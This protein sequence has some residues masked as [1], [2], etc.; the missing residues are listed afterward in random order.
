M[1]DDVIEET[2]EMNPLLLM[3]LCI[4]C[5]YGNIE[6]DSDIDTDNDTSREGGSNISLGRG[7][8]SIIVIVVVMNV[9]VSMME[10]M[11]EMA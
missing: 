11:G 9:I 4:H 10:R 6:N 3:L 7:I 2:A 8:D 1:N 5:N